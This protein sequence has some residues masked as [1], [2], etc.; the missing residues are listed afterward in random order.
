MAFFSF[1]VVPPVSDSA[2]S[3]CR[4]V[5]DQ[6]DQLEK[7]LHGQHQALELL[8]EIRLSYLRDRVF[9]DALD[10]GWLDM[11]RDPVFFNDVAASARSF[12]CLTIDLDLFSHVNNTYGHGGGNAVLDRFVSEIVLVLAKS[13]RKKD[14]FF[15]RSGGD[16][17]L[18]LIRDITPERLQSVAQRILVKVSQHERFFAGLRKL[19]VIEENEHYTKDTLTVSMGVSTLTLP[20]RFPLDAKQVAGFVTTLLSTSDERLYMSKSAGRGRYTD[21]T[22]TFAI[23]DVQHFV[24]H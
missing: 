3:G 1:L 6:F 9:P 19:P 23:A 4:E 17:F 14:T 12:S 2:F 24:D 16:E 15:I 21:W 22:G 20:K 18:V 7:L 11:F 13:S 10:A 8:S 5:I